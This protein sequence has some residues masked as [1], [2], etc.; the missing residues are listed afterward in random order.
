[1]VGDDDRQMIART[2]SG[3]AERPAHA[4]RRPADGTPPCG[5]A[6]AARPREPR[7]KVFLRGRMQTGEC[8]VDITIHNVSSRGLMV[9]CGA[10]LERGRYVEVRCGSHVLVGRV[11][12]CGGYRFGLR[13]RDIIDPARLLGMPAQALSAQHLPET[14]AA[15]SSPARRTATER[16]ATNRHVSRTL[17]FAWIA[18]MTLAA[19]ILLAGEV[20]QL[21]AKPLGSASAAI[22]ASN[23]GSS[24][25]VARHP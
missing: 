19:A 3:S 18:V 4:P 12:W 13:T 1:M 20:R 15:A 10:A 8:W 7:F 6:A 5:D 22:S 25:T 17:Q 14:A 23:P 11:V 21:L 9:Q 16:H 24:Q 2:Q